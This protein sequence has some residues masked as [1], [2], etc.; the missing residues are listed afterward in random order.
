VDNAQPLYFAQ[1]LRQASGVPH[2]LVYR[3]ASGGDHYNVPDYNLPPEQAALEH[4]QRH[5]EAFPPELD[6]NIVWLETVNEVDRTR[7]EWLAQFSLATARLSLAQGYRWA[8]FGWSSGEP[9][10]EHWQSP[11]MLEFLRLVGA[12]PDRLAIAIHEY[13]YTEENIWDAYP[14]KVGR[15]LELFR[16][17]DQYGI[18]R[19]TVLITEWGWTYERVPSPEQAMRDIAWAARLYAP[20]PQVKGAAIWFLG[21]GYSQIANEAQRLIQPLL[22]YTLT[23]YFVAPPGPILAPPNPELYRP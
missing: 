12:N 23:N 4:W 13:S 10:P 3:K 1:Q 7:S 9:E 2:V 11:A 21:S 16:I 5:I 14:Y 15:F 18:P 8:A 17:C 22:V 19:P 20:Y 6:P